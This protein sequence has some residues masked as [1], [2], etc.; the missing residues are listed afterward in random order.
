MRLG[1]RWNLTGIIAPYRARKSSIYCEL[2]DRMAG[3]LHPMGHAGG[4][5]VKGIMGEILRPARLW[6]HLTH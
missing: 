5:T 6:N 1:C 4:R 2:L 3:I